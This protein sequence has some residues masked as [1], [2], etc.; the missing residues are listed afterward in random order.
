MERQAEATLLKGKG[1]G[2]RQWRETEE[3]KKKPN[4]VFSDIVVQESHI[5]TERER[6]EQPVDTLTL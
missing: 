1:G 3:R 2:G 5:V 4:N 6:E